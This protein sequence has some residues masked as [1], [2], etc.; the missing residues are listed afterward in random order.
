MPFVLLLLAFLLYVQEPWLE[1]L[2]EIDAAEAV[3]ATVSGLGFFVVAAVGLAAATRLLLRI[4]PYSRHTL[5]TRFSSLRRIHFFLMTVF[6]AGSWYVLGFGWAVSTSLPGP[7]EAF[8]KLAVM[9][10]YLL[11]LVLT[12]VV[13]YDV[14]NAAHDFIWIAGD[15]PYLGRWTYVTLNVRHS[16]FLFVPMLLLMTLLAVVQK[17]APDLNQH[18]DYPVHAASLLLGMAAGAVIAMPWMLRIFLGLRPLPEGE[19][20][21]R[22][23]AVARRTHFRFGDILVWNTRGT[24]ANALVTGVLPVVR[25]I[26]LTDRLITELSAEELEAVFGHEIGHVKHRHMLVY[27][28]FIIL[29]LVLLGGAWT[30]LVEAIS[31]HWGPQWPGLP[32]VLAR[33]EWLLAIVVVYMFLVFGLLSRSCERQADLYGCQVGTRPAFIR[34]LE[35]VA[36]INGIKMDNPGVLAAWLHGSMGERVRF[37]QGLDADPRA[38]GRAQRA[39]GVLKWSLT[40]GLLAGVAVLVG[41]QPWSWV[42]YLTM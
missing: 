15:R 30:I 20:R 28:L 5:L 8:A 36:D 19:L 12:W 13:Y 37:L 39:I 16:L 9:V 33:Q 27:G 17:T 25:Y 29:S 6:F 38:E 21:D 3:L 34:A 26:V 42:K 23:K 22:L 41:T 18:D 14:D 32:G 11:A 2:F 10:P 35:K 4:F 7:W 31:A 40:I 1:P 24:V